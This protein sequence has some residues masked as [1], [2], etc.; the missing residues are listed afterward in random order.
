MLTN[1]RARV[2]AESA[3]GVHHDPEP[4]PEPHA[5]HEAVAN[6]GGVLR[7][8]ERGRRGERT[9]HLSGLA[10]RR[11]VDAA[12]ELGARVHTHHVTVGRHEACGAGPAPHRVRDLDPRRVERAVHLGPL[13]LRG[14]RLEVAQ[15]VGLLLRVVAQRPGGRD[16]A[17]AIGR[18]AHVHAVAALC[19]VVD[20]AP[21]HRASGGSGRHQVRVRHG[22][23]LHLH[24]VEREQ[25]AP[26]HGVP[27]ISGRAGRVLDTSRGGHARDDGGVLDAGGR[28]PAH[29]GEHDVARA[30][31]RMV[32]AVDRVIRALHVHAE[33]AVL[34]D[35]IE[36]PCGRRAVADS[37]RELGGGDRGGR[38]GW[39][40]E[41]RGPRD[42]GLC[43]V[44]PDDLLVGGARA[45]SDLR[46]ASHL[47]PA[48]GHEP[49]ARRGRARA[50]GGDFGRSPR[51]VAHVDPQPL[52][53]VARI[54]PTA[55]AG[56]HAQRRR[57]GR[58]PVVQRRGRRRAAR[59]D[60]AADPRLRDRRCGRTPPRHSP[61]SRLR[62]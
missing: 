38:R 28:R 52:A 51:V 45:R 55:V 61:G 18:G 34:L 29:I 13:E 27:G 46:Q 19:A 1:H 20:R 49:G 26:R 22:E 21:H 4:A 11:L 33:R 2:R 35:L 48:Q 54:G 56:R 57:R 5:V 41:R 23:Q 15:V 31:E 7:L 44:D 9:T 17:G 16:R 25:A 62:P 24:G 53:P 14:V 12:L 58:R 42:R 36:V 60:H 8:G 47:E 10:G 30:G 32:H 37:Q 43:L 6:Q 59:T 40:S 50:R 39:R 3:R